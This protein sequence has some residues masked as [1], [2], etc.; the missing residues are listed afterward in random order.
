MGINKV[1]F[2]RGLSM[3]ELA[4][5]PPAQNWRSS[6]PSTHSRAISKPR[7]PEPAIRS[8]LPSTY[9]AISPRFNI[10][11]TAV[12]NYPSSLPDRFGHR[13]PLSVI[14][15]GSSARLRFA[16]NQVCTFFLRPLPQ[17]A[18]HWNL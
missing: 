3:A 12:S 1:Q 10:D 8:T 18:A 2:Q 17:E 15:N 4:T 6:A 5:V 14:R 7:F 9:I 11:S 13:P 16:A